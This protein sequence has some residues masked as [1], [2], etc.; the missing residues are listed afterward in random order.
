MGFKS[1][2]RVGGILVGLYVEVI[3]TCFKSCPRVGGILQ[4]LGLGPC[5]MRFKSCPR[6]GGIPATT[7]TAGIN[8]VSSRAPVWGASDEAGSGGG[9]SKS[10]KSCPRVGGI[11]IQLLEPEILPSFKSCPRVGGICLQSPDS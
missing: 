7:V 1:C 2:P 3:E 9:P 11:Q 5:L 6:V 10:F 4:V 8:L